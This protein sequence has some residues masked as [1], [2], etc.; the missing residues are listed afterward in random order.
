MKRLRNDQREQLLEVLQNAPKENA[1]VRL[2]LEGLRRREIEHITRDNLL[3]NN[4]LLV[5]HPRPRIIHI[6][7]DTVQAI[8]HAG[9]DLCINRWVLVDRIEELGR[10]INLPY[11]LNSNVLRMT[12]IHDATKKGTPTKEI[13]LH[14]GL[15]RLDQVQTIQNRVRSLS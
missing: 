11:R 3:P 6:H 14:L 7:P 13:Q 9:P 5:T 12:Y 10:L 8:R 1:I 2:M 15:S 4:R